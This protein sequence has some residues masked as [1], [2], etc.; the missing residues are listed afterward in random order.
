MAKKKKKA[1]KRKSSKKKAPKKKKTTDP[2]IPSAKKSSA[3]EVTTPGMPSLTILPKENGV[4]VIPV[5]VEDS[6]KLEDSVK[7]EV[8]G[9]VYKVDVPSVDIH[10]GEKWRRKGARRI[11]RITEVMEKSI[12]AELLEGVPKRRVGA[13]VTFTR[14]DL[15]ANWERV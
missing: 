4:P 14:E 9:R 2:E 10:V 5:N 13:Q 15:L 7:P 12:G 1:A 8:Q 6:V 3:E 11:V